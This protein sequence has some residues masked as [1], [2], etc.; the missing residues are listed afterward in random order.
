[1]NTLLKNIFAFCILALTL[2]SH[3][4]TKPTCYIFD[5]GCEAASRLPTAA[6]V[7]NNTGF[8]FEPNLHSQIYS[9]ETGIFFSHPDHP[10]TLFLMFKVGKVA[11]Y[12][13]SYSGDFTLDIDVVIDDGSEEAP[14]IKY[15]SHNL[16]SNA[17]ATSDINLSDSSKNYTTTLF[18]GSPY[19]LFKDQVYF[20]S[21]NYDKNIGDYS[22][23]LNFQI[24][25]NTRIFNI[26][27]LE[28]FKLSA[29]SH[30]R[31]AYYPDSFVQ[32]VKAGID[33]YVSNYRS[34]CYA[35][36][37]WK[38]CQSFALSTDPFYQI[39]GG[40]YT[41]WNKQKASIKPKSA[42]GES[43]LKDLSKRI[44]SEANTKVYPIE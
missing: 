21:F 40:Q 6:E 38:A 16:P 42:H 27:Y 35:R 41:A 37:T 13:Y 14:K 8:V 39:K 9:P 44:V 29:E 23:Q 25:H 7:K 15:I 12:V 32:V 33:T 10:K 34:K 43:L 20:V 11:D 3:A 17:D 4:V 19:N 5:L 1:M 36:R 26:H 30:Y 2:N 24:G 28:M 31:G 18:V 22:A